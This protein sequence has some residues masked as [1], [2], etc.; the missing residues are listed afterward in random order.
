[1]NQ[2]E[3]IICAAATVLYQQVLPISSLYAATKDSI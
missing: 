2:P 3:L 1:M